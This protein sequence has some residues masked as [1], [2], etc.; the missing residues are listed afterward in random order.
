MIHEK[1]VILVS[2][3]LDSCILAGFAQREAKELLF[4]HVNYGQ[5]TL[6]RELKA[7]HNIAD[8][9]RVKERLVTDISYLKEIGSSCITDRKIDVPLGQFNEEA[10]PVSYVP[11][12]NAHFLAI[13]VSWGEVRGATAT[14]IGAIEV[15]SSGYPDCRQSF[16]DAFNSAV[17]EGTKPETDIVIKA[18][19]VNLQ[20]KDL[21]LMGNSL[22]AP[23]HLTWSCYRNEDIACG[24]CDSC[25]LRL[26]A[27]EEAGIQDPIPYSTR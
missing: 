24:E 4:L 15:D 10:I 6:K 3:G 17:K 1:G 9:Y 14:Y 18:P 23:L 21:I 2:G 25:Y 19:F 11:F 26:K 16:I 12:R 20:K 7:F 13:A 8:H 27:F 22:N 5:R